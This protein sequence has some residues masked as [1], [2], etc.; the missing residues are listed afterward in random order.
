[1]PKSPFFANWE[2][3]KGMN[4]LMQGDIIIRSKGEY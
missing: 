2:K 1:M 3:I 4:N